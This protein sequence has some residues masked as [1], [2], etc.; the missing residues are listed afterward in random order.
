MEEVDVPLPPKLTRSRSRAPRV[1]INEEPAV[2]EIEARPE[3]KRSR[4]KTPEPIIEPV[5]EPVIEPPKRKPRKKP[6]PGSVPPR[7]VAFKSARGPIN[8][9]AYAQPPYR[10]HEPS[11]L[12]RGPYEHLH[13]SNRFSHIMSAW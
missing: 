7:D 4:R 10:S 8:F 1:K 12:S 9:T 3:A 11:P 13:G 2:Q 5:I 6:E